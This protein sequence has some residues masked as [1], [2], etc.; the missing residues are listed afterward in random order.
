M[1]AINKAIEDNTTVRALIMLQDRVDIL[2]LDRRL[3]EQNVSV[4]ERANIVITTL[5]QKALETQGPVIDYLSSRSAADVVEYQSFWAA[6]IIAVEAIPALLLELSERPG[7]GYLQID[8]KLE[9]DKPVDEAPAEVIPNDVEPG[10][11]AINAHKMWA[12]GFTGAGTIVMGIDTGVDGNHPALNYKW[13]GTHVPW[14][15]AW[16]DPNTGTNFPNDC[17]SHGTH[18]IGTMSGL[19]P[20]TNDTIGVAIGAEWI[21]AKTL[22]SG[23]HTSASIAAFQW[24]MDPD[25]NPGTTDDMP[26]AI[27][28]SWYDPNISTS[29]QCNPAQNPY[30]DVLTA[31]EAAGI[32][33]V[34]SAG[35]S[36]PGAQSITSPKN[37][38]IDEVHFWATGA[39]D[40]NTPGYPIAGFS[41][42]GPVVSACSTG[43]PSLDI[44]PEAS[45]PGVSVRSAVLNGNY[46]FKSGTSMACPHVV[47]AIALLKE[48]HPNRTGHELKMALY[49]TAVDLGAS[50][51]DNTYGMG[52]IDVWAAHESLADPNDPNDPE[53]VSAYSD[54]NTPTSV[55]LNWTDPTTYVNGDPLTNFTIEIYRD[56]AFA[57][58]V[59]SGV[60]MYSD[61][62]LNDGQ[63]YEYTVHAKDFNDS[64]SNGV[65]VSVFS[66]GSPVPAAPE[67]LSAT[68]TATDATLTWNDPV[69]QEDG[70]PL[71][72]LDH[73][74]VYRDGVV[75]ASVAPGTETYTDTPTPGFLYT[76][77]VTAVD[78]ETPPNESDP[79]NEAGVF[80]G[81]SPDFLVWVGP[82][83]SAASALSGDS[84][85]DALVANGES[86]FL[87]NN[88]FEFGN[89]LSMFQGVFVVLGIFSNNHILGAGDPEATAL[90]AYLAGGGNLYLEGGDCFYYD[91]LFA[92]GYDINPWFSCDPL[93]DGSSGPTVFNLNGLNDLSAFQFAYNGENNW[94]DDLSAISSTE[95]WQESGSGSIYGLFHTGYAGGS[96]RAIGVVASF[97]GMVDNPAQLSREF[98]TAQKYSREK[99]EGAYKNRPQ[100]GEREPFV[101]KAA[102]YREL[103]TQISPEKP[104]YKITASGLELLA[105]TKEDLMAAYLGLFGSSVD[106]AITVTPAAISDTLLAGGS[107]D[108]LLNIA[109]TGGNQA[110][111][112]TYSISENPAVDWLSVTPDSGTAGANQSDNVIVALDASMLSAGSY[113]TTL[114][115]ASNDPATPL[116]TVAVELLV[117]GSPVMTVTPDSLFASLSAGQTATETITIGNSGTGPLDFVV[118]IEDSAAANAKVDI[119]SGGEPINDQV[120]AVGTPVPL[121]QFA[122]RF[123]QTVNSN[124]VPDIRRAYTVS[125][126]KLGSSATAEGEEIFGS[127]QN[128]FGPSTQKSRGNIFSCTT[129]TTLTEHRLYLN[130]TTATDIQFLVYEGDA[131]SGVY[132]LVSVSESASAGP[133]EGWYSSGAISNPMTTGKYYCIV[134][135]W[136]VPANYYNEQN[137]ALY[138]LPA[139][140]GELIAGAGWDW[141]PFYSVPPVTMQNIPSTAFG[142]PVAYYQTIVTGAGTGWLSV[143]PETGMAD[144]GSSAD[145]TVTFES[146]G[147][148]I[149]DYDAE[150][151]VSGTDPMNSAD[152]VHARLTVTGDQIIR[153]NPDPVVFPGPVFV[154]NSDQ[155]SLWVAN[156]GN[157]ILT[158]S[159]ITSGNAAFSLDSTAF[160]VPPF[161]SVEVTVTFT[162][163]ATGTISGSL[164][165]TS[166]ASNAPTLGVGVQGEAVNPPVAVV[167]PTEILENV[168]VGDTMDVA[169]QIENQGE[170]DLEWSAGLTFSATSLRVT[171][172]IGPVSDQAEANLS[173]SPHSQGISLVIEDA[174]DLQYSYNPEVVTGEPGNAGA[175]FDGTYFYSTRW[176]SNLLHK[177]DLSGNLVE[178]FSIPGVTGLRDLAFDGTFMYGGAAANSIYI[179]DFAAKTLVGTI[180][181]PV[182]VRHIAYDEGADAFWVGN[183]AD[184]PTLVDRNGKT[185]AVLN[186]NLSSQYGSAYDKYS[187]G[188]PYLWVFDQGAGPGSPQYIHQFNLNTGTATGFVH[189]VTTDFPAAAGIAGGL[190]IGEGV[191]KG[192]ASIGGILQGTPG[193]YFMYELVP[194]LDW[195]SFDP[196]TPNFGMV[197]PGE[198][199]SFTLRL[200]PIEPTIYSG[201][202]VIGTNDPVNPEISIAVELGTVGI[203]EDELLP[204]TFAVSRNYPNPFNPTTT[205]DYQLPQASVVKLEIYNVLGQKVRTL[206]NGSMQP[207]RYQAVWDAHNDAGTPV[208]SGIYIYRFEAENYKNVQKMILLK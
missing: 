31:V 166:N 168:S 24:A 207:G 124:E 181:S 77:T 78:N 29:E 125:S 176:A 66:G 57:A 148:P 149:G 92:G 15:Q 84:L 155:T 74:N 50:G 133:G 23:T 43:V 67:N 188:G 63:F 119:I 35:N 174:W 194:P 101:K 177:V 52:I 147:L 12:A 5:Q 95:I 48:A 32:A 82:N 97:G 169:V 113:A 33:V 144:P 102:C 56:G 122:N 197:A 151:I 182:A 86:V 14:Q 120:L 45:A 185:L 171:P 55:L 130:V 115:I 139:S 76:Y 156:D 154:G 51:E 28:N 112:L 90:D 75:V 30:I 199:G 186:T 183:W 85:F 83:A 87:T 80:I 81:P 167:T 118:T 88:L 196:A 68:T 161:D 20:S 26:V 111:D 6:N 126:E 72:D 49:Q 39:V 70:T 16:F 79:G 61:M 42:R 123:P 159:D 96:G 36:G 22:C 114:E 142:S 145:V 44:K 98:R 109:N 187:E 143:S 64:L 1:D 200:H 107:T 69:T 170:A 190:W 59:S 106:P 172:F 205:I 104:F 8:G 38:N 184:P 40:G 175:E 13:R 93:S 116:V 89:D 198:I 153:A 53:N 4:K 94:M 131:I 192:K 73:I 91:P 100:R 128:V 180:P 179:M 11:R 18:T 65:N 208:G 121:E 164:T 103:K 189:D 21:A 136:I 47:G 105:N 129:S 204:A 137:I 146:A 150:I 58:S 7:V 173:G 71:D 117:N 2:E 162:P 127:A 62:G 99:K 132:H 37:V 193:M 203:S 34:F 19:Q 46:G 178:E 202:V 108:W 157:G 135:Q 165:I 60:E 195:M 201:S 163:T 160:D 140:F 17:D 152:T 158:V 25:G 27:G 134:S 141:S 138:P 9:W 10:L 110:G 41:S 54:F 3:Y 191:V 206:V